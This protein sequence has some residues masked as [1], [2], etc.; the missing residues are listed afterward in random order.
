MGRDAGGRDDAPSFLL[1][2]GCSFR[3][4]AGTKVPMEFESPA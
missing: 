4:L 3:D 1:A 2:L